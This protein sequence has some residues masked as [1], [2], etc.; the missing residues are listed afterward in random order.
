MRGRVDKTCARV[1][2][3]ASH[4]SVARFIMPRLCPLVNAHRT[5]SYPQEV[6]AG[7]TK[8]VRRIL[9]R[10]MP[11]QRM[12]SASSGL[13]L[14]RKCRS[15]SLSL[16]R[17][18]PPISL[19]SA[20]FREATEN[21]RPGS[22]YT[23]AKSIVRSHMLNFVVGLGPSLP[24]RR[25]S[26]RLGQVWSMRASVIVTLYIVLRPRNVRSECATVGS[27]LTCVALPSPVACL[28][29]GEAGVVGVLP[30]A[31]DGHTDVGRLHHRGQA[32]S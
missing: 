26:Y 29:R 23:S 20:I 24:R 22:L 19:A 5:G 21:L 7:E 4:M 12:L 27:G 3:P 28:R 15:L 31:R 2:C 32:P 16:S 9:I 1:S 18:A 14:A 25:A 6:P 8:G 30:S 17:R 11:R 13:A 10:R